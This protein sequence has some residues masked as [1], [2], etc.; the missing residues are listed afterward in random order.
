M[1]SSFSALNETEL[2]ARLACLSSGRCQLWLLLGGIWAT[3][4]PSAEVSFIQCFVLMG[5]R[6]VPA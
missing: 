1:W 2:D 6:I 3:A 5:L 4:Y